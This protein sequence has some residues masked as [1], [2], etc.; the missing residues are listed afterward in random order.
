MTKTLVEKLEELRTH[1]IEIDGA[2]VHRNIH[3]LL[4]RTKAMTE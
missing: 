3:E 2:D 1:D 4:A